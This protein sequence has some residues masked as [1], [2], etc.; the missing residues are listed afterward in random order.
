[1]RPP[2]YSNDFSPKYDQ[3][4]SVEMANADKLMVSMAEPALPSVLN[5]ESILKFAAFVWP[6]AMRAVV[7]VIPVR[8]Q[9]STVQNGAV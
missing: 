3:P 7:S 5:A 9:M 2:K 4:K 1:M 8:L 6:S